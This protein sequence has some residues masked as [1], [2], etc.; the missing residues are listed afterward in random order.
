[1]TTPTLSELLVIVDQRAP[2]LTTAQ[3]NT[4]ATAA[5]ALFSEPKWQ[6]RKFFSP[7]AAVRVAL[8]RR[9]R[10]VHHHS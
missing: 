1:M 2:T 6:K 7:A 10:F 9:H 4:V 5:L 3:K 8:M